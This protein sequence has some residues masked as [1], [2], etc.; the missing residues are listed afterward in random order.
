M[1]LTYPKLIKCH[2]L[3]SSGPRHSES[4]DWIIPETYSQKINIT[5]PHN[6][7]SPISTLIFTYLHYKRLYFARTKM[8]TIVCASVFIFDTHAKEKKNNAS[9]RNMRAGASFFSIYS[10]ASPK[11]YIN[12]L[13][14]VLWLMLLFIMKG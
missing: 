13:K 4:K 12:L 3:S 2:I 11:E 14:D 5:Q 8:I 10:S 6:R 9:K 1:V 7:D